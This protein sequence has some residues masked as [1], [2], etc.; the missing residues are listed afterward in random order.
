[1]P[2]QV[3]ENIK[4]DRV[5]RLIAL[6]NELE[7]KYYDKFKGKMVDVLIEECDNGISFG[8]TS[9]YLYVKLNENLEIGKIIEREL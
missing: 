7:K 6:S 9:N 3:S 2:E 8:H 1:M 4:K 5:K